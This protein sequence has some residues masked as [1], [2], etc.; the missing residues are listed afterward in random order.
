MSELK[1]RHIEQLKS[2][3]ITC[4][5]AELR[6][7][8]SRSAQEKRVVNLETRLQELSDSVCSYEKLRVQ[9][10]VTLASLQ[11]ELERLHSEKQELV[12]AASAEP[13]AEEDIGEDQKNLK[14]I[15]EKVLKYKKSCFWRLMSGRYPTSMKCP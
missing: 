6:K 14:K 15:V 8:E 12:R 9:D 1:R 4:E 10:K 11:D 2:S 13:L 7:L 5:R 3:E